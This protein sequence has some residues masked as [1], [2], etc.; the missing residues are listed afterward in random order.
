VAIVHRVGDLS[1]CYISVVISFASAHR[2][3][4]FEACRYSI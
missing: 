2:N 1:V 3:A 4:S